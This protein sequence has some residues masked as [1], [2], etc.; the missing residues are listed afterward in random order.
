M[1]DQKNP[2]RTREEQ[3]II[4]KVASALQ[5]VWG[6]DPS[7]AQ[8]NA[9]YAVAEKACEVCFSELRAGAEAIY[10]VWYDYE[11]WNDFENEEDFR[12]CEAP[13]KEK[14]IVYLRPPVPREAELAAEV[15]RLHAALVQ[16]DQFITNGIEFGYI[17]MPDL[18]TPDSA[19]ET[20]GMIRAAL[21]AAPEMRG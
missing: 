14:R 10:Q 20:P 5:P 19:H 1:T 13:D 3:K 12:Q 8:L 21:A 7:E 15:E 16:A 2:P 4:N 18:D 17:S 6:Y 11:G 9:F